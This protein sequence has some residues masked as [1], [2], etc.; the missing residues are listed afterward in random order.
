ML[1]FFFFFFFLKTHPRINRFFSSSFHR[2]PLSPS[3]SLTH[4]LTLARAHSVYRSIPSIESKRIF[5]RPKS[6]IQL[7]PRPS[8]RLLLTFFLFKSLSFSLSR[9]FSFSHH[10]SRNLSPLLSFYMIQ[11]KSSRGSS[12]P[13]S[14]VYKRVSLS[15]S[16]CF[17][18][19]K[20]KSVDETASSR[21][22]VRFLPLAAP[23][24]LQLEP[25]PPRPS[26]PPPSPDDRRRSSLRA[27]HTALG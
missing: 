22:T 12:N 25:L 19:G 18:R 15:L 21:K 10:H 6:L 26:P 8:N 20:L 3:L 7:R 16:R 23:S 9:S 24:P 11:D 4:S 17:E 13:D 2:P 1:R 14:G 5:Y 27:W